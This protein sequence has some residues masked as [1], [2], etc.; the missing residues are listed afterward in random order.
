MIKHLKGLSA[1][2][3]NKKLSVH[4]QVEEDQSP[5]FLLFPSDEREQ[6]TV[7]QQIPCRMCHVRVEELITVRCAHISTHRSCYSSTSYG[8]RRVRIK[9]RTHDRWSCCNIIKWKLSSLVTH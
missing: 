2:T 3:T 1:S 5:L 7:V 8:L 4:H 6:R 9:E